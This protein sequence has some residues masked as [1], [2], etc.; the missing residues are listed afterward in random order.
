MQR[1]GDV[2]TFSHATRPFMIHG[3]SMTGQ[4]SETASEVIGPSYTGFILRLDY[5]KEDQTYQAVLPQTLSEPY[6]TTYIERYE[7]GSAKEH[8]FIA[9]SYGARLK[10]DF[11]DEIL[12]LINKRNKPIGPPR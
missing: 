12:E 4:F 3:H 7:I 6:W 10:K 8:Y 5:H 11:K 2:Y 9:F 1:D